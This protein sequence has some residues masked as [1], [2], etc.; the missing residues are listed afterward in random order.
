MPSGKK[1]KTMSPKH[2]IIRQNK[3]HY[4]TLAI[5]NRTSERATKTLSANESKDYSR[6]LSVFLRGIIRRDLL[7]YT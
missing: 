5:M 1:I 7:S 3:V 6:L 2:N 4:S